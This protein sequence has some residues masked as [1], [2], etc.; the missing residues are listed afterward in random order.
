[1]NRNRLGSKLPGG[2][3]IKKFWFALLS[4]VV[5][6]TTRSLAVSPAFALGDCGKNYHRNKYGKCVYGGQNE[7]YCLK[8]EGHPATRMPNGTMVCK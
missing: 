1:M 8:T 7:D 4:A 3:L 2:A 5:V 6:S